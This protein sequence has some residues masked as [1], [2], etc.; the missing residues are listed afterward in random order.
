MVQIDFF[1]KNIISTLVPVFSLKPDILYFLYDKEYDCEKDRND[2]RDAIL[3]RLPNTSI[4]YLS[5]I[6]I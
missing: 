2:F 1:D 5:L 6:H 3:Y 4:E